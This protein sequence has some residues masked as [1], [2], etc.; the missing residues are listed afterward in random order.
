MTLN[1][2]RNVFLG[3]FLSAS[4]FI[5]AQENHSESHEEKKFDPKEMIMHH[6]KDAYGFHII[7]INDHAISIPLPVILWTENGLTTFMSSEFHHDSEGKVVV[8]K[9]GGKFVNYHEKVYQLN[10]GETALIVGEDHYPVNAQKPWDISI[11]K[12]V[13]M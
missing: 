4:F 11:T 9:N 3:V 7:D 5:S 12:N 13:F 1:A 2:I 10:A 6:I 8:E